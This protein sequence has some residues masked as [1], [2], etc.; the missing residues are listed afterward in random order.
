M[1]QRLRLAT[2]RTMA[3]E[4]IAK[5]VSVGEFFGVEDNDNSEEFKDFKCWDEKIK[6]LEKWIN[7]E[8]PIA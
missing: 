5:L 7:E 2:Q 3:R 1:N 6:E 4:A 8:S